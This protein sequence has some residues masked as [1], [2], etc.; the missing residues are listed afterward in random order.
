MAA[1]RSLRG[2]RQ[3]GLGSRSPEPPP[4]P[5]P[6]SAPCPDGAATRLQAQ[7]STRAR[8]AAQGARGRCT[9]VVPRT[10]APTQRDGPYTPLHIRSL[11]AVGCLG[12]L[13]RSLRTL[14]SFRTRH[15]V[16]LDLLRASVLG[17][18]SL[19]SSAVT[20]FT[21]IARACGTYG[22]G[23]GRSSRVPRG[24]FKG[25][26]CT[27]LSGTTT[28]EVR[29]LAVASADTDAHGREAGRRWCESTRAPA[30]GCRVQIIEAARAASIDVDCEFLT[31][32]RRATPQHGDH[33]GF[34]FSVLI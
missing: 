28:A 13:A 9:G 33:A 20:S 26:R 2:R 10:G 17:A 5:P 23:A 18:A 7:S 14:S 16:C 12:C 24:R 22:S 1:A 31:R 29:E 25:P 11:S 8:R 30:Q 3:R 19:L 21:K 27:Q 4:P 34:L 32:G 15:T 6:N